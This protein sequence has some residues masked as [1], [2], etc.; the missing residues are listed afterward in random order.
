VKTICKGY[1][2]LGVLALAALAACQPASE[3]SVVDTA[4]DEAAVRKVADELYRH[5]ESENWDAASQ[6]YRDDALVI[7]PGSPVIDKQTL[8]GG[9]GQSESS[10]P[11]NATTKWIVDSQEVVV[12]GDLAYERGSY[13]ARVVDKTTGEAVPGIA[14]NPEIIFVHIFKRE[15][16]GDWKAWRYHPAPNV[17]QSPP[18][19][20]AVN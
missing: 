15:P 6:L 16:G 19:A 5:L 12:S 3:N 17:P 14:Q 9:L 8:F 7:A 10:L 13:T 11:P 20:P 2:P 4:A 1:M 18:A